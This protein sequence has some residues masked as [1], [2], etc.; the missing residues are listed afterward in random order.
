MYIYIY[1]CVH[2]HIVGGI[3]W[4]L[5]FGVK[6]KLVTLTL[7]IQVNKQYKLWA[8]KSI[9]YTYFGLLGYHVAPGFRC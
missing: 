1:I 7:G 9:D 3:C 4:G 2:I 5:G 6:A 8:L